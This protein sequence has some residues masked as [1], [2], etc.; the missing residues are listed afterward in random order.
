MTKIMMLLLVS[1]LNYTSLL[2][3]D[4][5]C[6]QKLDDSLAGLDALGI[7]LHAN[8]DTLL[9]LLLPLAPVASS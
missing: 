5:V 6:T 8:D 3:L 1:L 7:I 4:S 2:L 9:A